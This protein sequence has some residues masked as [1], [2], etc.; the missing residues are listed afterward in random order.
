MLI[1][2][3]HNGQA[4]PLVP[5]ARAG[6]PTLP[7]VEGN[8]WV[9][10]GKRPVSTNPPSATLAAHPWAR[11]PERWANS[12]PLAHVRVEG[13]G[14]GREPHDHRQAAR[15]HAGADDR[16]ICASGSGLDSE[17]READHWEH[18]RRTDASHEHR[19]DG[20]LGAAQP[21]PVLRQTHMTSRT[22]C[23]ASPAIHLTSVVISL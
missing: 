16:P 19:S 12:R 4:V 11:R 22:P 21:V 18:R 14:P 20:S 10:T 2:D 9:I 15:L 8:S 17:R 7:Y 5:I 3:F 1:D 6:M 23:P 13:A